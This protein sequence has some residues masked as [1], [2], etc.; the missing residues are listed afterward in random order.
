MQ[1]TLHSNL[2]SS[3]VKSRGMVEEVKA[4]AFFRSDRTRLR[5]ELLFRGFESRLNKNSL[6]SSCF[7]KILM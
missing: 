1:E 4:L 7:N 5:G 2:E 6:F 3:T